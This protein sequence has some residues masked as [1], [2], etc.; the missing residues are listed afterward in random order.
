MGN[1]LE[2]T[3][4]GESFV[5]ALIKA[6]NHYLIPDGFDGYYIDRSS[7]RRSSKLWLRYLRTRT[8]KSYGRCR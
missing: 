6:H 4:K 2:L 8:I 1:V 3:T 5:K 7:M